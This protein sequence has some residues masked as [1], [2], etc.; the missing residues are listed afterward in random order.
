MKPTDETVPSAIGLAGPRRQWF[1]PLGIGLVAVALNIAAYYLLP[2]ELIRRLGSFGYLG[3]F[4]VTALAN[5]TVVVPVPYYGLV[6]RLAQELNLIGV[7]LAGALGS[8]LGESV[9]FF[10]GRSGRAA[11]EDTRFYRW[12][13]QQLRH[14]WRAFVVLFLLA[15]PPNP[16]FDVAGLTAGALGL[17]YRLFLGA[18]FLG[19]IIRVGLIAL[20]GA[21]LDS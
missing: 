14:P 6:A 9:A 19:R 18:V 1:R 17:P 21:G 3:V 10:V 12:V 7:V 4:A 2:Q 13:Q 20:L 11:V 5:A 16:A 8:A 15:A